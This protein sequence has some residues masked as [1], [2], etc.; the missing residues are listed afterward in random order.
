L[1]KP[2]PIASA[3]SAEAPKKH[4]SKGDRLFDGL[5]DVV[6]NYVGTFA[7]TLGIAHWL[8]HGG[9]KG[10]VDRGTKRLE[11][12]L[13]RV[14]LGGYAGQ[15]MTTSILMPG[16]SVMLIPLHYL[17]KHR[18]PIV[19]WFNRQLGDTTDPAQLI[20]PPQQS[21]GS[22]IKGR[23]VAWAV[24]FSSLVGVTSL[25][26]KDKVK[27][28]ENGFAKNVV[29]KIFD[30]PTHQLADG[31]A[32]LNG[33]KPVETK[34]FQYG[35]I[36]AVDIFAT[37]ASTALL[38]VSS[39]FFAKKRDE[40]QQR[41]AASSTEAP[42]TINRYTEDTAT[43]MDV[44]NDRHAPETTISGYKELDTQARSVAVSR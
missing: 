10:M 27:E 25:L 23:L 9:G 28:L 14:K 38:F 21:W 2:H 26:G 35:I 13:G 19:A 43:H 8:Q 40:K 33:G 3:D 12:W 5:V 11:N 39:R 42:R 16:G 17:E 24:V 44:A 31:F 22:L 1:T 30:K 18:K 7:A 29:C 20:E 36:A 37:A 4:S 41:R 6:F 34:T 15:V 32:V